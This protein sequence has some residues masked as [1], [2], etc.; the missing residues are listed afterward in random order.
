MFNFTQY[1][2]FRTANWALPQRHPNICHCFKIPVWNSA[3]AQTDFFSQYLTFQS[4]APVQT[5]SKYQCPRLMMSSKK[6]DS[7]RNWPN[8]SGVTQ[9]P[10]SV[11]SNLVGVKYALFKYLHFFKWHCQLLFNVAASCNSDGVILVLE[12]WK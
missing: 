8:S 5:Q 4:S 3:I 1:F 2:F 7:V 12:V 9:N 6:V 10:Q 11:P